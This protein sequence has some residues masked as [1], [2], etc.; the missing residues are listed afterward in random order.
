MVF[1]RLAAPAALCTLRRAAA[2]CR[3]LAILEPHRISGQTRRNSCAAERAD[4]GVLARDI[5]SI[6]LARAHLRTHGG[7]GGARDRVPPWSCLHT[8]RYH[9]TAVAFGRGQ[10]T[11]QL[12]SAWKAAFRACCRGLAAP[13]YETGSAPPSLRRRATKSF[14]ASLIAGSSGGGWKPAR[15]S[16]ATRLARSVALLAPSSDQAP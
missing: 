6:E 11:P 10:R 12:I 13:S 7:R 1:F 2:R 5:E 4:D 3:E 9:I 14:K 16:R 8:D 15:V